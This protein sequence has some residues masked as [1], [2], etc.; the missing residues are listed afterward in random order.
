MRGLVDVAFTLLVMSHCVDDVL[1]D[2]LAA[3]FLGCMS[4]L[5]ADKFDRQ[6]GR[7]SGH[8]SFHF[9]HAPC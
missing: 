2:F 9:S 5:S 3:S 1:Q 4:W 7:E 6:P 8:L